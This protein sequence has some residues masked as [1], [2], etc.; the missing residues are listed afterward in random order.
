[1]ALAASRARLTMEY[2][3]I[4]YNIIQGIERR[5]W[6]WSVSIDGMSL[7]GQ[8]ETKSDAIAAAERAIDRAIKAKRVRPV[9]PEKPSHD[10][11][12]S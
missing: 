5:T 10:D 1:M 12:S 2:Q 6:S 4:R 8:A 11:R 9:P 7:A 3:G